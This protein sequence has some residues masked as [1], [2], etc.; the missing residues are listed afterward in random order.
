MNQRYEQINDGYFSSM[1]NSWVL[2]LT[3]GHKLCKFFSILSGRMKRDLNFFEPDQ[4][5][6]C[7]ALLCFLLSI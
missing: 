6:R 3:L 7:V 2:I 4:S 1:V 5:I